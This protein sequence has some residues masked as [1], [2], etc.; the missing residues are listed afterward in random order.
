MRKLTFLIALSF[1]ISGNVSA[2]G[3][4]GGIIRDKVREKAIE[5]VTKVNDEEEVVESEEQEEQE[6]SEDQ[7]ETQEPTP[8]EKPSKLKLETKSQY[9][10]VPG[11]R[12]LFFDDF[13]QDAIG[14]FPALWTG[15]GSGEVKTV[16]LAPGKW[17][18]LTADDQVYNLAKDLNLPE[19]F[20]FEFDL[21]PASVEEDDYYDFYLTLYN[22]TNDF[23]DDDLYPG[24][25][26][27]HI[28]I[29]PDQWQVMGYDIEKD[30][31]DGQSNLSPVVPETPTHVIVWVQK[32]RLRIYHQGAKVIDMPTLMYTP[33]NFN[34]LRYSMWN[35]QGN[36][37]ISNIRFTTASPD[38]RSKLITEGKLISYGI[39]F[40]VNSDKIKPESKGAV[41]EIAKVLNE[42]PD[43]RIKIEGHTD[44]DGDET[45]NMDLSKRRAASVKNML[46]SD[47][48]VDGSRIE[49]DGYGESKP[50]GSNST[51]EGKAQN[52]R[53]EFIKL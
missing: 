53:V 25:R 49:T 38:T 45:K 26:G 16:N 47:Y 1:L 23:M 44:S 10:F 42:N 3:V 33:T 18:H 12:I 27:V 14:D 21:I 11:D 48:S 35:H 4:L 43:V 15:S 37:L 2:Q 9:D 40:D 20:I 5:K 6:V 51:S 13:S 28:S 22:S 19:N 30:S 52:R 46:V 32:A 24:T 29:Y 31:R 50:I 17:F 41:G 8:Q 34:R 7:Q 36:P 39:Y